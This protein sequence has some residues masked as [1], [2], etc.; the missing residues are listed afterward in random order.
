MVS[1]LE[2]APLSWDKH[3]PWRYHWGPRLWMPSHTND[4]QDYI[5]ALTALQN[6][7]RAAAL[8]DISLWISPP[9]WKW[10]KL[11]SWFQNLSSHSLS[12]LRNS[13][14]THP[15]QVLKL[16]SLSHPW[17]FSFISTHPWSISKS[18]SSAF[19]RSRPTIWPPSWFCPPSSPIG[20][21]QQPPPWSSCSLSVPT[22]SWRDPVNMW[23][24]PHP[25]PAQSPAL[26]P[27][28]SG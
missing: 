5:P 11:N 28:H 8:P 10:P 13:I 23:A 9:N 19:N 26:A 27:S 18:V 22:C 4:H 1:G 3:S 21:S 16:K 17:L 12:H 20:P 25:S 24:R 7:L 14:T 15:L 6:P 2:F